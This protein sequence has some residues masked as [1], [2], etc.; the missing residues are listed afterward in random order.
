MAT[1]MAFDSSKCLGVTSGATGK[2]YNADKSGF[3]HVDDPRDVEALK[4]GGYNPVS[5]MPV[6]RR[7]WTC[8]PCSRDA[9]I[10]HCAKCGSDDLQLVER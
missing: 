8:A 7:Y 10:N 4:A 6:L 5:G 9:M 3:I 2:T 1:K